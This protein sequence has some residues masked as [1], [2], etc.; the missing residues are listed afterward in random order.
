[1]RV[2]D[3][4]QN[5]GTREAGQSF[6]RLLSCGFAPDNTVALMTRH[7]YEHDTRSSDIDEIMENE[8][9]YDKL[10]FDRI[11]T[12]ASSAPGGI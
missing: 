8:E 7:G 5:T 10:P 9:S 4:I 12:V 3:E 2:C 11:E 1:M 6:Y